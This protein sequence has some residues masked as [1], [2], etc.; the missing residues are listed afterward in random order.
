MCSPCLDAPAL[1]LEPAREAAKGEK[2]GR[3]AIQRAHAQ[4]LRLIEDAVLIPQVI[5]T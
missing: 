3:R 2:D 1:H 5:E 4:R